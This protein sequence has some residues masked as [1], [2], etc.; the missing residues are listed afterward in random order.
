MEQLFNKC[1]FCGGVVSHDSDAL[2]REMYDAY[3][4]GDDALVGFYRCTRCGRDFEVSD[5]S[6]E[7]R[8]GDY[9]EYWNQKA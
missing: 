4:E 5:P 6:Q 3:E 8:E 7:E 9:A 1:P 2:G